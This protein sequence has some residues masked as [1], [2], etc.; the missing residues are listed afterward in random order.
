MN[1][2]LKKKN[3]LA[4]AGIVSSVLGIVNAVPS[5]LKENYTWAIG[6]TILLVAGLVLVAIAWGD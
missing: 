1:M 4:I 5:Y 6:S 2:N 3:L